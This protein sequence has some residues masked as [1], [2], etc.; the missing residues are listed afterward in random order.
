M[1]VQNYLLI[2]SDIVT[3]CV[4]W[5]GNTQTWK[6]PVDATML[7]QATTLAMV[8]LLNADKTDYVLT[9]VMGA[10]N[11]GFTWDGTVCITNQPKP[12]PL[13]TI[14]VV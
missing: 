9:E 13:P 7:V 12:L 1:T 5:D 10:G 14:P 11:I 2:Q 3:N 4:V 6:P 8:W